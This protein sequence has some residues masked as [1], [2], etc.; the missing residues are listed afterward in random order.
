MKKWALHLT[1]GALI[2]GALIWTGIGTRDNTVAR[3]AEKSTSKSDAVATLKALSDGFADVAEKVLP[4]VVRIE[5]TKLFRE[6][7][8]RREWF[9]PFQ[10]E[11][12]GPQRERQRRGEGSGFI[13]SEDGY[14]ITNNHV[15]ARPPRAAE[16]SL[17]VIVSGVGSFR[18]S[19]E[20]VYT[21]PDTELAIIKIDAT[22]LPAVELGDS[23]EL[24]VGEW[25]LAIGH[26]FGL[27]HSVSA[28][29][30]SALGRNPHI[31]RDRQIYEHFIQTDAAI[32][33][34]NS[35]GPLVNLDGK[36]VGVNVA[37]LTA[38]PFS[39]GNDG[40]AFAIPVNTVKEIK[41]ELITKGYVDRGWLGVYISQ[42]D[43]GLAE[44]YDLERPPGAEV[45]GVLEG[46]PAEEGGLRENDFIL[47]YNGKEIT[48]PNQFTWEVAK[49]SPGSRVP[50]VLLR[51]GKKKEIRIKVGEKESPD[52]PVV[53]TTGKTEFGIDVRPVSIEV[54]TIGG[55]R[56][57]EGLAVTSVE[58]DSV[59][60][61]VEIS[62][63]D[64]IVKVN[65]KPVG[66]LADFERRLAETP[67]GKRA[68]LLLY[69]P[70]ELGQYVPKT[71]TVP[72]E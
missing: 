56:E 59:A 5:T 34:G 9:G 52:R 25:V 6:Q 39:R 70:N 62:V 26:P 3:A 65:N 11:L 16:H 23:D 44:V 31:A 60:H 37:I 68:L 32:N 40:I 7:G 1:T 20:N 13:I 72:V 47:E 67:K 22:G 49:T 58:F 10:F 18:V 4:S 48:S 30:V 42:A 66:S 50:L 64:I 57:V 24:R 2:V 53:S 71:L 27:A 43:P 19:E 12:P 51:D 38:S 69:R 15:V 35:G 17:E 14:I 54:E 8:W 46:S 21:D 36:V 55:T 28:G 33:M 29:I 63:R 61:F 41:D 45:I